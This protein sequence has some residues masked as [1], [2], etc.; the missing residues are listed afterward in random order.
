MQIDRID[1]L[2]YAHSSRIDLNDETRI[3]AASQE[4][5]EWRQQHANDGGTL[6]M[7]PSG[8]ATDKHFQFLPQTLSR[9]SSI[10]RSR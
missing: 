4:A 7:P 9:T 3:N 1:P 6:T 2:Y 5:E 10:S 8:V